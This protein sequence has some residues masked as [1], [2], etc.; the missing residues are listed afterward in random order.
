MHV[1]QATLHHLPFALESFDFIYSI[2]VLHHLPDPE[3]ALRNLLR[4]LKPG[5]EIQIYLYW[6]PEGQPL[7][8]AMLA[9]VTAIRHLS[10]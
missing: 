8:R 6:K 1:V 9:V 7:K 3:V 5:G 2:G 10:D 4:F